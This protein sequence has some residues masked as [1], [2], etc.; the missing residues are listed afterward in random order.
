MKYYDDQKRIRANLLGAKLLVIDDNADQ[1]LV[2]QRAIQQV[3]PELKLSWADS[4]QQAITLLE[5]WQLEEWEMPKL[6]LLDLYMPQAV[7]GWQLLEEIKSMP[8]P[9]NRIPIVML[10]S[11]TDRIDIRRAYELGVSSYIVKPTDFR[12]WLTCCQEIH[13]YWWETAKLAPQQ[14]YIY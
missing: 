14:V 10:T 3:K 6:I 5:G 8:L 13:Q 4:A 12:G 2:I 9:I 1:W 7:D 11:S